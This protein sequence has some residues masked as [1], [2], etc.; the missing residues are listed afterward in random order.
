MHRQRSKSD[1]EAGNPPYAAPVT[2]R[3]PQERRTDSISFGKREGPGASEIRTRR[4]H[5]V[6][7]RFEH[8]LPQNRLLKSDLRKR[9]PRRQIN[10]TSEGTLIYGSNRRRDE[11][12]RFSA[13]GQ[14]T[15]CVIF[16]KNEKTDQKTGRRRILKMVQGRRS[17]TNFSPLPQKCEFSNSLKM[18]LSIISKNSLRDS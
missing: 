2:V 3:P 9:K 5:W 6:L 11:T 1:P 15:S 17:W 12:W 14:N 16:P 8:D 18:G 4:N 7:F 13:F 10:S